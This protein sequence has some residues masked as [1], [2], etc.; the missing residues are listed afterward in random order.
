MK[1]LALAA[2]VVA[3]LLC[4]TS[5]ADAQF[6]NRGNRNGYSYPSYSYPGT[7]YATPSYYNGSTI[8]GNSYAPSYYNGGVVTSGYTPTPAT[9]VSDVAG[10]YLNQVLPG[11]YTPSYAYPSAY[12]SYPSYGG[13][14]PMYSGSSSRGMFGRRR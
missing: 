8:V 11:A 5:S 14:S 12:G 4:S 3:G 7:S 6:R 2:M 10:S 9:V 13:Y 1:S